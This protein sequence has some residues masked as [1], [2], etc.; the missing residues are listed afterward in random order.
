M[1]QEQQRHLSTV[2]CLFHGSVPHLSVFTVRIGHQL[3]PTHRGAERVVAFSLKP[4]NLPF[5]RATPEL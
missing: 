5:K 1:L 4:G 2:C 3:S